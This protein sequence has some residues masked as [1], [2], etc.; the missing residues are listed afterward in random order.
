M[1]TLPRTQDT[2]RCTR[3]AWPT[4]YY[5][6]DGTPLCLACQSATGRWREVFPQRHPAPAP[7]VG[8]DPA[9]LAGCL[10][11]LEHSSRRA[12]GITTLAA[13]DA[14]M[15]G[16]CDALDAQREDERGEVA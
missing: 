14:Y 2:P 10:D 12:G 6:A 13:H 9:Y 11:G 1:A 5:V 15:L 7:A 8:P 4:L 3:C 16:Y